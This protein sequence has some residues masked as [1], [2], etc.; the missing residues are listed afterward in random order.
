M[1]ID[2]RT[3]VARAL[4]VSIAYVAK[5]EFAQL[6]RG[7]SNREIAEQILWALQALDGLQKNE[8]P[9]YDAWDALL[10]LTWYQPSQI[11]LAYTLA[12]SIT[13]NR[14]PL[15]AGLGRL[16][17]VDFGCGALAMQFGLALAGAETLRRHGRCPKFAIVPMDESDH[18]QQIG[19]QTWRRLIQEI[20]DTDKYPQHRH[21]LQVCTTMTKRGRHRCSEETCWLTVLHVAYEEN[22][23]EVKIR[24]DKG[25]CE[26][27]PDVLL[28][29]ARPLAHKWA[30]SHD[31]PKAYEKREKLL[32]F[33][34]LAIEGMLEATT[35]F[36]RS[37]HKLYGQDIDKVA[38]SQGGRA[39]S[40]YL[41]NSVLW[42]P[43]NFEA[44]Y[45]LYLR[46]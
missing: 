23:E 37:L 42:A 20:A 45:D 6:S 30:Y 2:T 39:I 17:V 38:H 8:M 26:W 13:P 4:D 22:V 32:T 12:R 9:D 27:K 34:N 21:L 43:K 33:E 10:Y 1:D 41:S 36:R 29:M 44:K 19:E 28:V 15:V 24:L 3:A 16:Q 35:E 14:N 11:N 25:V 7:L 46:R 5:K 40:Y 18:M 31:E